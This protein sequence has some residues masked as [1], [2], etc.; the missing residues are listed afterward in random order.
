MDIDVFV[1][2]NCVKVVV[3]FIVVFVVI[4]LVDNVYVY[5][6]NSDFI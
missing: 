3:E 6:V 2:N 5:I 1:I 4:F